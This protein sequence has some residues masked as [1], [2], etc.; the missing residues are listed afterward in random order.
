VCQPAVEEAPE[1]HGC[2][3]DDEQCNHLIKFTNSLIY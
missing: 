1:R 2:V 3:A